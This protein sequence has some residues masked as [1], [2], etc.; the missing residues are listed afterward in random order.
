MNRLSL[1]LVWWLGGIAAFTAINSIFL[2][3]VVGMD[4]LFHVAPQI[5]IPLFVP[6]LCICA[7]IVTTLVRSV[8]R[9]ISAPRIMTSTEDAT[10]SASGVM[11]WLNTPSLHS[12]VVI[13]RRNSTDNSNARERRVYASTV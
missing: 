13:L 2:V 7:G 3:L 8:R 4:V 1:N 9:L 11:H 5:V 12:A 10:D 6:A